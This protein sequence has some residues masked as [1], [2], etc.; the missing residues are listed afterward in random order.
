MSGRVTEP[1][2]AR[3][4]RRTATAAAFGAD[5]ALSVLA[6]TALGSR[7]LAIAVFEATAAYGLV[8]L[9][10]DRTRPTGFGVLAGGLLA[11]VVLLVA[12]LLTAALAGS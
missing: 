3:R 7:G 5:L 9:V 8:L 4:Q 11:L 6:A 10:G 1:E 12:L 2:W